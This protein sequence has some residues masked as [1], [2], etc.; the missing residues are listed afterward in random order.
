METLLSQKERPRY[1][2][3]LLEKLLLNE[4]SFLERINLL[5]ILNFSILFNMTIPEWQEFQWHDMFAVRNHN[6]CYVVSY[7][8]K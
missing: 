1:I 7:S 3:D 4:V 6:N 5:W 8:K 2:F